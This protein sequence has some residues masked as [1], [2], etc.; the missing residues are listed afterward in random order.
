[1][2]KAV[3]A[4]QVL[5]LAQPDN[6]VD[7][8][9]E[10][11]ALHTDNV[12]QPL[13]DLLLESNGDILIRLHKSDFY[14]CTNTDDGG[15]DFCRPNEYASAKFLFIIPDVMVLKKDFKLK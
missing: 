9:T 4:N 13:F 11:E 7:F 14:L 10:K 6:E 5:Q 3:E 2:L 12:N 1:M 8:V 15:V